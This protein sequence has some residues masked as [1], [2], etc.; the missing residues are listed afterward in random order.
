MCSLIFFYKILEFQFQLDL[1]EKKMLILIVYYSFRKGF[2]KENRK[3]NDTVSAKTKEQMIEK[4]AQLKTDLTILDVQN[5]GKRKGDPIPIETFCEV[6]STSGSGRT[7]PNHTHSNR[8][9]VNLN[10]L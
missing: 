9:Q 1:I 6:P 5:N 2:Q 10:N 7:E 4:V 3:D 8:G